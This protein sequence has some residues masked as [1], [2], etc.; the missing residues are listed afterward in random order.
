VRYK[1]GELRSENPIPTPLGHTRME[2]VMGR[3]LT[4]LL[5]DPR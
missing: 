5:A 3:V 1:Q 2:F 4:H